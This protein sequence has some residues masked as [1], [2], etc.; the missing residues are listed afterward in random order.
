MRKAGQCPLKSPLMPRASF[1]VSTLA[2]LAYC[3]STLWSEIATSLEALSDPQV[4]KREK[5]RRTKLKNEKQ[6]T[7]EQEKQKARESQ[8]ATE[9]QRERKSE[10]PTEKKQDRV[11]NGCMCRAPTGS[12][13]HC[14]HA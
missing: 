13:Q 1:Y 8:M 11:C 5:Y 14:T 4:P 9:K 7:K 6:N 12:T 3:P 2:K 10:T